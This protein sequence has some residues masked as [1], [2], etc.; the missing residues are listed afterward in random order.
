MTTVVCVTSNLV[1]MH[2]MVKRGVENVFL[3]ERCK[4]SSTT[5]YTKHEVY[6]W[7]PEGAVSCQHLE[8]RTLR[9]T[10][11]R[12]ASSANRLSTELGDR[13]WSII[14]KMTGGRT[15][16]TVRSTK[17]DRYSVRPRRQRVPGDN[18]QMSHK[19]VEREEAGFAKHSHNLTTIVDE[20]PGG[21]QLADATTAGKT[22]TA[23]YL[24]LGGREG[25]ERRALGSHHPGDDILD[26][27]IMSGACRKLRIDTISLLQ[28]ETDELILLCDPNRKFCSDDY[29]ACE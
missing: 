8:R 18:F 25:Q 29:L 13:L 6:R 24:E 1:C 3:G 19:D 26:H 5:T 23:N 9:A 27:T 20:K 10:K 22:K 4:V 7:P 21:R 2:V 16:T 17:G 28:A 12:T 15:E 11:R 14:S